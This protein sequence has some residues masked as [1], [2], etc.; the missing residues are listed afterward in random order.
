M[1]TRI[2]KWGNSLALRIP[3]AFAEEIGLA[4]NSLVNLSLK[5]GGL[6][7]TAASGEKWSLTEL[8]LR[9]TDENRHREWETGAPGGSERW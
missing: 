3:S 9:V 6:V 4:E 1:Q 7:I 2:Q 5:E 8:L